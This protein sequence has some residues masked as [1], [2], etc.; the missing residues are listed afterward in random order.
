MWRYGGVGLNEG[1]MLVQRWMIASFEMFTGLKTRVVGFSYR[2][3]SRALLQ[4]PG[5][6]FLSMQ[7][8]WWV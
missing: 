4:A 3:D 7:V 2:F 6:F 1:V 8:D 5:V